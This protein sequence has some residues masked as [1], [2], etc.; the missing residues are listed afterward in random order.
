MKGSRRQWVKAF[1]DKIETD[2]PDVR[3]HLLAAMG[4]VHHRH[5]LNPP[6]RDA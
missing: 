6:K 5:L 4:R 3:A 1:L 2:V